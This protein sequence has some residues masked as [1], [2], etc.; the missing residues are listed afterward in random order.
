M[1]DHRDGPQP[2]FIDECPF[3]RTG[4]PVLVAFPEGNPRHGTW[5]VQCSNYFCMASGGA[6]PSA[7]QAVEVWNRR[8]EFE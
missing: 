1:R 4:G 7:E 8:D 5:Q 3:C 2:H 6:F